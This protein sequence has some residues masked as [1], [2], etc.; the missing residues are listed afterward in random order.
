M[1]KLSVD[2]LLGQ[3]T[4]AVLREG[5]VVGTAWL[6]SQEGHLLTAGHVLCKDDSSSDEVSDEVQVRFSDDAPP[7]SC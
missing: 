5:E 2:E 1:S 7:S 6:A 3:A 4:C